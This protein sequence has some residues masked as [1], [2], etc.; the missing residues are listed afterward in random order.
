[1]QG[2]SKRAIAVVFLA[3]AL[4]V[5]GCAQDIRKTGYFPLEQDLAQIQVGT[6][7]KE[8]VI[9]AIGSP[10]VTS[11]S[12]N[13]I[14]Y[15]GQRTQYIGPL[16]PQLLER[17]VIAVYFDSRDRVSSVETLSAEDGADVVLAQKITE[18]AGEGLS[19]FRQLFGNIGNVD[20]GQLVGN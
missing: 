5:S 11:G 19:F 14:Y 6:S 3:S 9:G 16:P 20:A 13:A 10:S 4:L 18:P 7:S 2:R 17:Q 12:G 1:M 8:D 15:V